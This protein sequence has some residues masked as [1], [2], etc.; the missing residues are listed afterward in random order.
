MTPSLFFE[1]TGNIGKFLVI[2]IKKFKK[3]MQ[4]TNILSF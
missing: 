3:Y 4:I 2:L 1:E